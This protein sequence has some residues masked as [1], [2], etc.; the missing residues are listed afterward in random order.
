[1]GISSNQIAVQA[2]VLDAGRKRGMLEH[3]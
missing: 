2:V 3:A 1:M